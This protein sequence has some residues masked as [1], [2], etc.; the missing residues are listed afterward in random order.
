MR[1]PWR[2]LLRNITRPCPLDEAF[3]LPSGYGPFLPIS[4]EDVDSFNEAFSDELDSSFSSS[5]AC[6][7]DCYADF[8]A[9]WPDVTFR[10]DGTELMSMDTHW[11]VDA[12]RLSGVSTPAEY[13][14]LRRLVQCPRCLAF[15]SANIYLFE[16][17]FSAGRE[18]E[19]DIDTL[20]TIGSVTPF[21]LLEH[22]FAQRVLA[23]IREEG[24]RVKAEVLTQPLYR[25]RLYDDV[26]G[27]HQAPDDLATYG[28]AP[29][30]GTVEGRFNHAG[31]PML[32]LADAG[33]VAASELGAVGQACFVGTLRIL[34]PLKIFDLISPDGGSVDSDLF[35]ALAN[36]ALLAAPRTGDGWVKRQYVFSRFVADCARAAGFH[37]IRYG[38]T[39]MQTGVNYVILDTP[40]DLASLVRLEGHARTTCPAPAHRY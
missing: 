12:S 23:E 7:D 5:I 31:S 16:H 24:A 39:K 28:P 4:A 29:A 32:Y 18:M 30:S 25:A 20:I 33:A 6:C 35:D 15:D 22:R 1:Q 8:R 10:R 3:E 14:T 36:S 38:S 11:A 13:S 27:L 26:A 21:L 9:H 19:Y 17:R 37:A 2:I 34:A 40:D